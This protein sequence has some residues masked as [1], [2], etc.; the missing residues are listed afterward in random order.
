MN[1]RPA[2]PAIVTAAGHGSR[3]RPFTTIVPKEMLP[4]GPRPAVGHVIDECLAAGADLHAATEDLTHG[5]GNAAPVLT[6]RDYLAGCETFVVAFGDDI[7]LGGRRRP[8]GRPR[9]HRR[10]RG[11]RPARRELRPGGRHPAAPQPAYWRGHHTG[12]H[13]APPGP[14]TS[15]PSPPAASRTRPMTPED[16]A[17]L[18]D[19][20]TDRYEHIGAE[21]KRIAHTQGLWHRTFSCLATNPR[22]QTVLLQKKTPG[23]YSFD[24]P[25]YADVT[26][27]GHYEAGETIEDGVR[28]VHEELGLPISYHELHPIGIRQTAVSLGPNHIEREFQHWHL[29]PLT[30]DLADIPLADSEVA[31]LAE[32]TVDDA[33]GLAS[34]DL[35]EAPARFLR[36]HG[37]RFDEATLARDDLIP[38]YLTIDQLYLRLFLAARRYHGGQRQHLFW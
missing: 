38:G 3:F 10:V 26:V 13:A 2:C 17:M 29:L 31:G 36:R 28:E 4:I 23:R 22:T 27:G 24:R 25:D 8:G 18:I 30:H 6:L 19:I 37:N 12:E 5:Y 32:L 15:L 7:L 33:I 21:D 9:R 11:R 35:T 34:G 1:A 16:T 20:F 14:D